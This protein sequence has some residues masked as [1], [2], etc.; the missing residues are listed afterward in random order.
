MLGGDLTL[1]TA[2]GS[3]MALPVVTPERM[4]AGDRGT[5]PAPPLPPTLRC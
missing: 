5:G 3:F 1:W 4:K 2:P